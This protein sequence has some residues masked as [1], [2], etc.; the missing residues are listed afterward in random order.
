MSHSFDF[1]EVCF[2]SCLNLSDVLILLILS[3]SLDGASSNLD[4][5]FLAG[6]EDSSFSVGSGGVWLSKTDSLLLDGISTDF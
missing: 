6:G 2:S 5:L 3:G 1:F 4:F